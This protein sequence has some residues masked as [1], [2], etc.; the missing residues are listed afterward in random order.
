MGCGEGGGG[1]LGNSFGEVELGIIRLGREFSYG[2]V[3]SRREEQSEGNGII[4]LI[5]EV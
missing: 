1:G 4:W 2:I 3:W 5:G